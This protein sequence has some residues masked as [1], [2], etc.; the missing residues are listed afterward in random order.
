MPLRVNGYAVSELRLNGA[1]ITDKPQRLKTCHIDTSG[2]TVTYSLEGDENEYNVSFSVNQE[3]DTITYTWPD[4][5][6]CEVSID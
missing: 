4:G 2:G 6:I 1:V 3:T 5:F